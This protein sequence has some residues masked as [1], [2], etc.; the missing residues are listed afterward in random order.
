MNESTVNM[1]C[2]NCGSHNY[3]VFNNLEKL[4]IMAA[5]KDEDTWKVIKTNGISVTPIVCVNCGYV[6]LFHSPTT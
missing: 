1:L 4:F 5:E 3:S 6:L 2:P